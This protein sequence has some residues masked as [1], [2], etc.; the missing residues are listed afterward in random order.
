MRIMV[1][2]LYDVLLHKEFVRN[3]KVTD[4]FINEMPVKCILHDEIL[5]DSSLSETDYFS[6]METQ[7]DSGFMY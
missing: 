7:H 6:G 4:D 3:K 2:C 1:K 5:L